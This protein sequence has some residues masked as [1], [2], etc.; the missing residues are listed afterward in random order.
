MA[1]D[2]TVSIPQLIDNGWHNQVR[3]WSYLTE[4]DVATVSAA[5]YF[6]GSEINGVDLGVKTGDAI[7]ISNAAG[8]VA[9]ASAVFT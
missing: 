5:D 9:L 6:T 4:D 7:L 3:I 8:V 2:S 1:Y